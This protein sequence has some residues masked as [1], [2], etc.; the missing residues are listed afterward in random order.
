MAET[1]AQQA[2]R[3]RRDAEAYR[4]AGLTNAAA[5]TERLATKAER[6]K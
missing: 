5:R 1:P 6:A 4:A 2:A 3:L